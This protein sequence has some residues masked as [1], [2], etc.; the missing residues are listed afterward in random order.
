MPSPHTLSEKN[1][2]VVVNFLNGMTEREAIL[3]AGYKGWTK[4]K[5]IFERDEVRKEIERRQHQ[6]SSKAGVDA[7]WI[8]DRLKSIADAN[9]SDLLTLDEEGGGTD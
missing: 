3:A 6:M 1:R 5:D 8:I 2:K 7:D 4:T 9:L